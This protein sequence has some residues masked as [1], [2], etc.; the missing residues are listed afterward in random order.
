M[1]IYKVGLRQIFG[2]NHFFTDENKHRAQ[3]IGMDHA[4]QK[5]VRTA[6]VLQ[7]VE[8]HSMHYHE[9]SSPMTGEL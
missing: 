8:M 7:A 6:H 3:R 1:C 9:T 5:I 4:F 2:S